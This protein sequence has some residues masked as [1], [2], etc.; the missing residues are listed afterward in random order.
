[1]NNTSKLQ[2]TADSECKPETYFLWRTAFKNV[3][4]KRES[5]KSTNLFVWACVNAKTGQVEVSEVRAYNDELDADLVEGW[6]WRRFR[7]V[8]DTV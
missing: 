7:L 4:G 6:E 3:D 2:Q 5:V 1:M 8:E